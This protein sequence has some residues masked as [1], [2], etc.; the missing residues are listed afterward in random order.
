[1]ND[2][3]STTLALGHW[4]IYHR[5]DY[6]PLL[7]ILELVTV[8]ITGPTGNSH[9]QHSPSCASL[10]HADF[11]NVVLSFDS[12]FRSC[13][14]LLEFHFAFPCL[15]PVFELWSTTTNSLRTKLFAHVKRSPFPL[16]MDDH[17]LFT[18]ID[19]SSNMDI[20]SDEQTFP[21]ALDGHPQ[22]F[23]AVNFSSHVDIV[24]DEQLRGFHPIMSVF[25]P[26]DERLSG[27]L[28]M[29]AVPNPSILPLPTPM[30]CDPVPTPLLDDLSDEQLQGLHPFM[31]VSNTSFFPPSFSSS[32]ALT[33][34][35]VQLADYFLRLF[36]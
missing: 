13:R 26:D 28:P 24:S 25:P 11:S 10:A 4:A 3:W 23:A 8:Q 6:T 19:F 36:H 29:M 27:S 12:C 33:L 34:N 16:T 18:V 14:F 1:L 7:V 9:A 32:S 22:P 20:V 31:A 17:H 30:E 15:I 35:D 2:L 21:L 5:T